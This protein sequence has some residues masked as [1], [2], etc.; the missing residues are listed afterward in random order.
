MLYFL[1]LAVDTSF[2][3]SAA[4]ASA[5][6]FIVSFWGFFRS[7]SDEVEIV[8]PNIYLQCCMYVAA[9]D[10]TICTFS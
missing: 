8:K 7:K 10:T 9:S 4:L 2:R 5:L 1:I 6:I 3:G